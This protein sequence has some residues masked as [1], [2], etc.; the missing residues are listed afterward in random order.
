MK[1]IINLKIIILLIFFYS[2]SNQKKELSLNKKTENKNIIKEESQK[3]ESLVKRK[4]IYDIEKFQIKVFEAIEQNNLEFL[5]KNKKYIIKDYTINNLTALMEASI[6]G[7]YD[8]A[9]FLL[10]QGHNV[11]FQNKY[12]ETALMYLN[13]TPEII[14]LFIENGVKLHFQTYKTKR[15]AIMYAALENK[16]E[17]L[18]YYLIDLF[19]PSIDLYDIF[20][21]FYRKDRNGE[22]FIKI[23]Y[24]YIEKLNK[25]SLLVNRFISDSL[26]Y[27]DISKLI[28]KF[29]YPTLVDNFKNY[30]IKYKYPSLDNDLIY[31]FNK[32]REIF[33][34]A[35][36]YHDLKQ[37][38][39]NLE[40]N[41][42]IYFKRGTN[43]FCSLFRESG[44]LR[45]FCIRKIIHNNNITKKLYQYK[46]DNTFR[47]FK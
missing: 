12:G 44:D 3:K 43:E 47:E 41:N 7:N 10:A 37:I 31:Y 22:F 29:L 11:N 33:I 26:I 14:K 32:N 4:I 19:I 27:S 17:S 18:Y 6:G 1:V 8:I 30:I 38:L 21:F 42:L 5:K 9:E 24:M 28:K 16:E 40:T 25:A 36:R 13:D 2:C 34:N 46:N 39:I 35:L 15:T 20:E 23:C 45:D